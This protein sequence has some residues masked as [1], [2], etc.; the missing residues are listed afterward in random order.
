MKFRITEKRDRYFPQIKRG[1]F[2]K[3]EDLERW[4][5]DRIGDRLTDA[6]ILTNTNPIGFLSKESAEEILIM[7]K[8][9]PKIK[10]IREVGIAPKFNDGY[11]HF[12]I[13]GKTASYQIN[14]L[15]PT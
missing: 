14:K 10:N 3:W 2:K 1:M 9:Q 12:S 11:R 6:R 7:A 4:W 8:L 5:G 15:L 13:D